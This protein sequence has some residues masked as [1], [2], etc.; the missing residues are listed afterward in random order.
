MTTEMPGHVCQCM[1]RK[2]KRRK[3]DAH[4]P[5]LGFRLGKGEKVS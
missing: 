4:T 5:D 3:E 1:V 2:V